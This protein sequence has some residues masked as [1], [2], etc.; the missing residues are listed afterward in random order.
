MP[1]GLLAALPD[2]GHTRAGRRRGCA[3]RDWIFGMGR[4]SLFLESPIAQRLQEC[5]DIVLFLIGQSQ[6]PDEGRCPAL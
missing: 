4:P 1:I 3:M 5:D 6:V 2:V